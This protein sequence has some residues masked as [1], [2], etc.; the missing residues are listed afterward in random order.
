MKRTNE[1]PSSGRAGM[2]GNLY[3]YL[4]KLCNSGTFHKLI[5]NSLEACSMKNFAFL[6]SP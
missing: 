4:S 6:L 5:E 1:R 3:L 2:R